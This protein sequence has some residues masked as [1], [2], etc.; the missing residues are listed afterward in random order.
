MIIQFNSLLDW[1]CLLYLRLIL[2]KLNLI[3]HYSQDHVPF[4]ILLEIHTS[5][6][7][8]ENKER[9]APRANSAS[10]KLL[11]NLQLLRYIFVLWIA[12]RYERL[13]YVRHRRCDGRICA[14]PWFM[15]YRIWRG[16]WPDKVGQEPLAFQS[17]VVEFNLKFGGAVRI[18]P[19]LI[20]RSSHTYI[21]A[22]GDNVKIAA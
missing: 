18:P 15:N 3:K 16:T 10:A 13:R 14:A 5:F 2:V 4:I 1:T 17:P 6:C 22:D 9:T 20:S 7:F 11:K 12:N 8:S 21:H 19:Q